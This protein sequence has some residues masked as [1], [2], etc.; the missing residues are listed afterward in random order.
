MSSSEKEEDECDPPPVAGDRG[1]R[2]MKG[3][4]PE[5]RQSLSAAQYAF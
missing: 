4:E 1:D 5:T 2:V 3:A